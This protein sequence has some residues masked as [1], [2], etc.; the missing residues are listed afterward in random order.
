MLRNLARGRATLSE[1]A[2]FASRVALSAWLLAIG[3]GLPDN[4]QTAFLAGD[5][6][7]GSVR[8]RHVHAF[9]PTAIAETEVEIVR[10]RREIAPG[11]R[12][13]PTLLPPVLCAHTNRRPDCIAIRACSFEPD[14]DALTCV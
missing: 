6:L 14:R 8:P 5:C 4:D 3:C 2:G 9:G 7:S 1:R 11:A 10:V 12:A 13:K